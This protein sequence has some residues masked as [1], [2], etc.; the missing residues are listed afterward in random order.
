MESE[1]RLWRFQKPEW[2]NN[3]TI[4]TAGVYVSGALVR[5]PSTL[6]NFYSLY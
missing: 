2:L 4:R 5:L 1:T 3:S 6:P